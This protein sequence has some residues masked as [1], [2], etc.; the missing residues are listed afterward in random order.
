M[1]ILRHLQRFLY[2][3]PGSDAYN[4][5]VALKWGYQQALGLL[6]HSK[7]VFISDHHVGVKWL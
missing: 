1:K 6:P 3:K 4:V 2:Y 5:K 7:G